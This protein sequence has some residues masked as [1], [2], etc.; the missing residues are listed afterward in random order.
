[1]HISDTLSRSYLKETPEI[2]VDNEID[3]NSIVAQ[4][5]V[6]PSNLQKFEEAT[7]TD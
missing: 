5:P 4:L 1:M 7:A 2:N 6:S 3:I